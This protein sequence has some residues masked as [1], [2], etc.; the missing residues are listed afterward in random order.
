[1]FTN[2]ETGRSYKCLFYFHF[3]GQISSPCNL[4]RDFWDPHQRKYYN[5][6]HDQV[7]S[8]SSPRVKQGH[9]IDM[10]DLE[11]QTVCL[12]F[13]FKFNYQVHV[14]YSEISEI[15]TIEILQSPPR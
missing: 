15:L 12:L 2:K 6:Y 3:Q 11:F 7:Y 14:I 5:R 9:T 4:C 13:I 10:Y 8:L 1:M